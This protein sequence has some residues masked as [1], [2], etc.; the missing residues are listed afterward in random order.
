MLQNTDNQYIKD[1]PFKIVVLNVVGSSPTGHP[2]EESSN[3]FL[4]LFIEI[5]DILESLRLLYFLELM[6]F[7]VIIKKGAIRLPIFLIINSINESLCYS[8]VFF[9]AAVAQEWPPAADLLTMAEVDV[10]NE[11]FFLVVGSLIE[12]LTLRTGNKTAA[13]ELDTVGLSGRVR[14]KTYAVYGHYRQT[15]CHGMTALHCG[16]G[17]ALALLLLWGVRGLIADGCGVDEHFGALER[18]KACSLRIPLVPADEH[19]ELAYRGL[20]RVEA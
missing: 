19:S 20:Y 9:Y 8:A 5:P 7:R 11:A 6:V 18:H 15:V 1:L 17:R 2:T 3:A 4:F 13:P 12:Q 14:F 16:P 10:E